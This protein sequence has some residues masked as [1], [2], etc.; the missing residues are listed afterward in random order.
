MTVAENWIQKG[1]PIR[2]V[3]RI[4]GL[5]HSTYYW[6]RNNALKGPARQGGR[7]L[8]GYVYTRDGRRVSDEAVK[9]LLRSAIEGD[10]YPYGYHKLTHWLRR[11]QGLVINKKRVYR[12]C[13]EMDILLPQRPRRR[14]KAR[15]ISCNREVVTANQVWVT[16]IK[17][18]Y[19]V[20][21]RRFFFVQTI[22]DVADRMVID[23][24]IGLT[25][26]ADQAAQTLQ[27]ALDRRQ[28]EFDTSRPVIRSDNGPQFTSNAWLE[29]CEAHGLEYEHIPVRTP[30]K[31]AHIEA[32]HALL[33]D[34]CLSRYEFQTFTEAYIAVVEYIDY[35]NNRRIHGRLGYRTPV[36]YHDAITSNQEKM[37][38]IKL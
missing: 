32:F 11:E 14:R 19:I 29:T 15:R 24:H 13:K 16:D 27:G 33:Q 12:L 34:E 20:G 1:Y 37:A 10:G 17:Y 31:N 38:P 26:T 30:N 3:L 36:E 6:R 4:V 23:Y 5:S 9:D 8:P 7:P 22:M 35:Y 18:G 21:E 2:L 25:C 28:K